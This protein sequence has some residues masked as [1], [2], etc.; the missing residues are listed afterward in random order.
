MSHSS[1]PSLR[2]HKPTG[3][4]VVTVR[5]ASGGRKDLYCGG[6]ATA[7]AK[8]EYNR[9][10]GLLAANGGI[11]P[12]DGTDLTVAEALVKYVVF[13]DGYYR[14]PDGTPTG[15]ADDIK[16]TL[17]YIK[18][19]F[20]PTPLGEF[21]IQQLKLVREAMIA[22]DRVR[23][24]VNRRVG[25]VRGFVKWCVK[26]GLMSAVVLEGLRAVRPLAPG[27]SAAKEREPVQPADPT[28]VVKALPFLSKPLAA[29][30][31]LLRLTGARPSEILTMRPRDLDRTADVWVLSPARHKGSWRGKSRAVHFGPE[32]R[33]LLAPWLD[34]T[35]SADAY[36]FSPVRA[37]AERNAERGAGRKTPRWASH[38]A[39]NVTKRKGAKRARPIKD[40]YCHL[41]LSCAVRRACLKAKVTAFTP[42]SLRHLKAV[43]LR[44]RYGLEHVRA[45]LGHSFAGMSD[46][47]SKAADSALAARAAA[48]TG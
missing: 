11:Y 17:G 18:R 35:P 6:H 33:A 5:L 42:Y 14:N 21:G 25:M 10:V 44:E 26:A 3:Q 20:A 16:I 36:I 39:R 7:A 22:D 40:R 27:R 30:V 28:S 38:M 32:A 48:E 37:E 43:E 41:A 1:F 9:I 8:A 34:A 46:H 13:I 31:G 4:G 24:Q 12:D 29:V 23:N 19:L 15:T 47:Y 45:T 2:H